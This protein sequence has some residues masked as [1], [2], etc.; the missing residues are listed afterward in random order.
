VK[1][2]IKSWGNKSDLQK[3][4]FKKLIKE[5]N[6][7]NWSR[8]WEYPFVILNSDLKPGLKILEAGVKGSFLPKHCVKYGYDF[9]GI[10]M[11]DVEAN[12]WRFTKA[13]VRDLPFDSNIFDRV[14]C[15][16][17][18]EH[19]NDDPI[20]C[21]NEMLRVLKSGGLLSITTDINR[22]IN[23]NNKF[24]QLEFDVKIARHLGFESGI[25]P[26]DVLK[27]EDS[28]VGNIVGLGLSVIGFVVEK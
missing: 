20:I 19:I 2:K 22:L 11:Q 6:V 17:V 5:L 26:N 12:G 15:V 16:S 14:F 4:E 13:D 10:D 21:I 24:L 7:S 27:S 18:L 1:L 9:Y 25:M 23:S 28:D 8:N 3:P